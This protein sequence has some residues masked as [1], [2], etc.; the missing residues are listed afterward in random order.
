MTKPAA[1]TKPAP[2]TERRAG[3]DRR[4]R[5]LPPPAGERRRS[6]EPRKPEVTEIEITASQWDALHAPPAPADEGGPR[7]KTGH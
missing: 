2:G 6:V 7:G 5:E 3:A 4:K 1:E